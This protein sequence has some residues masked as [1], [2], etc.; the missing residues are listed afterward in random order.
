MK[1]YSFLIILLLI[2]LTGCEKI[3][4]Q[5]DLK[6]NWRLWIVSGGYTGEGFDSNFSHLNIPTNKHYEILRNDTLLEDG[7]YEIYTVESGWVG[8]RWRIEFN[9]NIVIEPGATFLSEG[10]FS[11]YSSDTLSFAEVLIDGFT[12]TFIKE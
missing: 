6:G 8:I 4:M 10:A 9:R 11:F 1:R 2:S 5:Q 3:Q 12:W 7:T